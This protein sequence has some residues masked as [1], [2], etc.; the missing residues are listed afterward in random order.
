MDRYLKSTEFLD[1][2]SFD[3]REKARRLTVGDQSKEGKAISLFCTSCGRTV[4]ERPV[5]KEIKGEEFVFCCE[6]CAEAYVASK[7]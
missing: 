4:V 1:W 6:H 5:K 3:L 7:E 2:D